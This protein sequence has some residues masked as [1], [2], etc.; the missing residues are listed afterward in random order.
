MREL[1]AALAEAAAGRAFVLHGGDCAES[2]A[3]FQPDGVR[4]TFRVLLQMAVI[5]I[6]GGARPVK[7]ARLAGTDGAQRCRDEH[8]A[9]YRPPRGPRGSNRAVVAGDHEQP[10]SPR[11]RP[12]RGTVRSPR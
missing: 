6:F 4:D 7:N 2:L 10:L 1:R 3:E 8:P 11:R 12:R 9:P 5:L